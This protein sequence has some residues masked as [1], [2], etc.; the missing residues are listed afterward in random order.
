MNA[1]ST[2]K[3][4]LF[5]TTWLCI[6]GVMTTLLLAAIS[7]KKRGK[8]NG[9]RIELR[10]VAENSFIDQKD[11]EQLIMKQTDGELEGVAVAAFDLQQLERDLENNTWV[12]EAEL[13][14]DNKDVLHITVTVKVP[15]GR[16]FT[17]AGNSFYIDSLGRRM[18]LS[19]K[20]TARVPVFTGFPDRK[21][22]MVKDS[23]LLNDMRNYANYIV[24][25]P[26]WMAQVAQIDITPD[27]RFV[28]V[29][30]IGDHT[31]L[32]GDGGNINQKFRRLFV[33]YQQVLSKTGFQ[34]YRLI[35][36]Q[37]AGQ[38]IA[39]DQSPDRKIDSVQ[40]RKNVEKM[41]RSSRDA[42]TDSTVRPTT[43]NGRNVVLEPDTDTNTD[44]SINPTTVPSP[45]P[46]AMK[47]KSLSNEKNKKEDKPKTSKPKDKEEKRVPKA[48]MP[49]K[50]PEDDNRGYY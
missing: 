31:V 4:I 46:N 20:K 12:R 11:V 47:T 23:L 7:K 30:T 45:D 33:F 6:A 5:V 14:F 8:C 37:F 44:P 39:S 35:D 48:V 25:D 13:Y 3:K 40:L 18:P 9:Y 24:N 26:F 16:V 27:R 38:V 43:A 17:T 42:K 15:V 1:K 22:L 2:I 19:E 29:P 28:M 34:K 50:V 49:P 32:L 21:V 36:V 10:G 41:I